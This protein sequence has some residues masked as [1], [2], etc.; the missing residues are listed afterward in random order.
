MFNSGWVGALGLDGGLRLTVPSMNRPNQTEPAIFQFR[1]VGLSFGI[2]I[3]SIPFLML[4]IY[5]VIMHSSV[6]F[7]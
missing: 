2:L 5:R 3:F 4:S 1:R 6:M 7:V